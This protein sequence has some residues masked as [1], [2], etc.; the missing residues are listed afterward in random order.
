[1]DI[2]FGSTITGQQITQKLED[3]PPISFVFEPSNPSDYSRKI[4]DTRI[5]DVNFGRTG[6][7]VETPPFEIRGE[8]GLYKVVALRE[9]TVPT[10]PNQSPEMVKAGDEVGSPNE[11]IPTW[12]YVRFCDAPLTEGDYF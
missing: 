9:W 8:I 10:E 11:L 6:E 5:K 1:M 4:I 3:K 2:N 7:V 12:D